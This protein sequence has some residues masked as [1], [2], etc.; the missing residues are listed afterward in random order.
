[1]DWLRNTSPVSSE[2]IYLKREYR[3]WWHILLGGE[4]CLNLPH[5]NYIHV[6]RFGTLSNECEGYIS[7]LRTRQKLLVLRPRDK[8]TK[9]VVLSVPFI[10]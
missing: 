4:V 3:L 7:Q 10:A 1:M 8:N 5:S 9:Y 2:R 6:F